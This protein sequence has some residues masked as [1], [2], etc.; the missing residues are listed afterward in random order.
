MPPQPSAC[1]R[2]ANAA[3]ILAITQQEPAVIH[4]WI[5]AC[6]EAGIRFAEGGDA[7]VLAPT[8]R[9][10]NPAPPEP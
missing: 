4:P 10:R 6:V 8:R 2:A 7:K 1:A 3:I 9:P 5:R